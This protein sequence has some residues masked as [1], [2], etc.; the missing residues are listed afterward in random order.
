MTLQLALHVTDHCVLFGH[1]FFSFVMPSG[2]HGF[3]QRILVRFR[4]ARPLPLGVSKA[5]ARASP[6]V[7]GCRSRARDT[8]G[9]KP[10]GMGAVAVCGR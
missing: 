4:V 2:T 6:C 9:A 1:I 10:Q 5:I 3:H 7:S 8:G